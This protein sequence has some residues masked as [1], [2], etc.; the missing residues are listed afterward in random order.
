[1]IS[2]STPNPA[3]DDRLAFTVAR[4][5]EAADCNAA[6][7]HRAVRTGKLIARKL[8]RKTVILRPDAL[9][10]LEAL[11]IRDLFWFS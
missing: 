11:P 2:S 10:W 8:G 9:A 1:M 6:T 4:L 7:I 5:A 3:L